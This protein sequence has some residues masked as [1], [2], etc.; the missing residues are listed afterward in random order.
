MRYSSKSDV[1]SFGVTL[2]EMFAFGATPEM[3]GCE[4]FFSADS[5]LEQ[6]RQDYEEWLRKL[7]NGQRLP[8]TDHCPENV[9]TVM[10]RCW[11]MDPAVRPSFY[12]LKQEL[13]HAELIVT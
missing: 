12:D 5:S 1:W 8:R 13:R 2:W 4:K 3:V 6:S 9:Y 7:E 10:L 11:H